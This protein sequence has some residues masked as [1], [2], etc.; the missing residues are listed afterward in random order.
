VV[1][2][3]TQTVGDVDLGA[4]DENCALVEYSAGEVEGCHRIL[5]WMLDDHPYLACQLSVFYHY[6]HRD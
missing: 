3:A 1:V 5:Q 6:T 4:E 2:E